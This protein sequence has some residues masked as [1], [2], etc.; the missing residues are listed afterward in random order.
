MDISTVQYPPLDLAETT[1]LG[2]R[3]TKYLARFNNYLMA[4]NIDDPNRKKALLL[5]FAGPEVY[6]IHDTLT[7]P[8][9]V[10]RRWYITT[11]TS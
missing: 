10:E 8:D 1:S 9:P 11:R 2:Q 4:L 3:W 5:H 7:I 6:D